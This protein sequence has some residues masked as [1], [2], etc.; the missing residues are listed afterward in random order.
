MTG[1]GK[2]VAVVRGGHQ[3]KAKRWGPRTHSY[4]TTIKTNVRGQRWVEL[5]VWAYSAL[6]A[7]SGSRIWYCV[8]NSELILTRT[9]QGPRPKNGRVS[10]RM[11]QAHCNQIRK[12]RETSKSSKRKAVLSMCV[13]EQ[14]TLDAGLNRNEDIVV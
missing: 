5:P 3:V 12:R 1:M 4:Q 13:P 2:R 6:K 7:R 10:S 11:R 8:R 14:E 9:P